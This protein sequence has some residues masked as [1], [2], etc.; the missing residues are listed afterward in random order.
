MV[1]FLP[2]D[3]SGRREIMVMFLVSKSLMFSSKE[4]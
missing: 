2:R 1:M 3:T 4:L